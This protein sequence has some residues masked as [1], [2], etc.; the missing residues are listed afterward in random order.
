QEGVIRFVDDTGTVHVDWDNGR[1]LGLIP[2]KD[3]FEI[4]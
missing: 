4:V 3:S 1:T 2:R